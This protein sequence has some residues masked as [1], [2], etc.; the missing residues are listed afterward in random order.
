MLL[1]TISGLTQNQHL[2][3]WESLNL[4][5]S[6]HTAGLFS[7]INT[8]MRSYHDHSQVSLLKQQYDY[9]YQNKPAIKMQLEK[10]PLKQIF[11][12]GIG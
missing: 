1:L 12:T 6:C 5:I 8:D 4:Q 2:K 11:F 7:C 10:F 9:N 3:L